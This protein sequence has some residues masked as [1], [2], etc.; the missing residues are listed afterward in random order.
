MANK[1]ELLAKMNEDW[2]HLA[3]ALDNV[4]SE[5]VE[6]VVLS[7]GDSLKRV[8]A[9]ITAWDGESKRRIQDAVDENASATHNPFDDDYWHQWEDEK[10][11]LKM[12]MRTQAVVFDMFRT[13]RDLIARIE[14]LHAGDFQRWVTQ[15]PRAGAP[16]LSAYISA[17]EAWRARWGNPAIAQNKPSLWQRLKNIRP[18]KA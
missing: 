12:M 15:D 18:P 2:A 17:I 13:R 7:G 11:G 3:R 5:T 4:P 8:C 16:H 9:L 1:K 14:A 6:N 10:I